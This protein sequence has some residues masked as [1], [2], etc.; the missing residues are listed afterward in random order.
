MLND[1]SIYLFHYRH[2]LQVTLLALYNMKQKGFLASASDGASFA[3]WEDTMRQRSPTFLFWDLVMRYETLIL[4]FVRAHREIN[5]SVLV[6]VLEQIVPLFFALDHTNYAR[7]VPNHAR[8][9]K[10]LPQSIR[11]EFQEHHHWV[12]SKSGNTFSAMLLNQAHEQEKKINGG[13]GAV[14]LTEN[15]VAFRYIQTSKIIFFLLRLLSM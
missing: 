15:P 5:F 10:S 9:M 14:G 7:W 4:I 1:T 6:D 12:L 3:E 11:H 13:R 2:A 8:D